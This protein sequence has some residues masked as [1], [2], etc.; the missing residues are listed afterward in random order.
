MPTASQYA[1]ETNA[2]KLRALAEYE[3]RKAA[4]PNGERL[5]ER[6]I[7]L[8]LKRTERRQEKYKAD[9]TFGDYLVD[10]K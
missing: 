9:L 8:E 10:W 5:C 3:K 6:C 7:R 4:L 1:K 2:K